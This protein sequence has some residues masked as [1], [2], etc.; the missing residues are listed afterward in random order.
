MLLGPGT[1]EIGTFLSNSST[2]S[3]MTLSIHYI[4]K[5]YFMTSLIGALVSYIRSSIAINVRKSPEI[6]GT[7]SR[8]DGRI[9][10]QVTLERKTILLSMRSLSHSNGL[11]FTTVKPRKTARLEES[12]F[13]DT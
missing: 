13:L 11:L 8:M 10:L 7:V 4:L 6:S 3:K 2:V 1:T 5:R 9:T 12:R